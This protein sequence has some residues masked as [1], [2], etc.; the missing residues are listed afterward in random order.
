[1]PDETKPADGECVA[2]PCSASSTKGPSGEKRRRDLALDFMMLRL[3][4]VRDPQIS[5]ADIQRRSEMIAWE[6]GWTCLLDGRPLAIIELHGPTGF[7]AHI[8]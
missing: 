8:Q 5:Q 1:M 7:T 4:M 3:A 2:T 6:G